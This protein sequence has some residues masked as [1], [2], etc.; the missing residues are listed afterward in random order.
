MAASACLLL[1]ASFA[2][3]GPQQDELI[4]W[5]LLLRPDWSFLHVQLGPTTLPLLEMAYLGNLKFYL[6]KIFPSHALQSLTL[7]RLLPASLTL[8]AC[9]IV[10]FIA[11]RQGGSLAASL[12][13]LLLLANPAFLIPRVCDWGPMAVSSLLFA[14]LL[15]LALAIPNRLHCR[16]LAFGVLCGLGLWDKLTFAAPMFVALAI[17]IHCNRP[18]IRHAGTFLGGLLLGSTPLLLAN[19]LHPWVSLRT[20]TQ[21]D[22]NNLPYKL[23]VLAQS[24]DGSAV[25]SYMLRE[26]APAAYWDRL[27]LGYATPI[28]LLLP[29]ALLLLPRNQPLPYLLLATSF[30]SWLLLSSRTSLAYSVHHSGLI[31]LAPELALGL[32]LAPALK[33]RPFLACALFAFL[34]L[35]LLRFHNSLDSLGPGPYWPLESRQLAQ[36]LVLYPEAH[37]TALD[38]G[39]KVPLEYQSNH[40]LT[41]KEDFGNFAQLHR[42]CPVTVC[43]YLAHARSLAQHPTPPPDEILHNRQSFPAIAVW[44]QPGLNP[45]SN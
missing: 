18:S 20:Q 34:T 26:V 37:I 15:F 35:P 22:W 17:A 24:L 41:I 25:Y 5:P 8:V 44:I 23:K 33:R 31:Q 13:G 32:L 14:L 38:W 1:H 12:T 3:F 4:W 39:L 9:G 45:V 7:L 2:S 42:P 11:N 30:L 10:I 16:S 6:Y 40:G 19:Y 21:W 28:L 43:I 29:V 36:Q 27:T